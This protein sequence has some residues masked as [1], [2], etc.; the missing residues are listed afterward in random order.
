MDWN[1]DGKI[2]GK[3]HAIYHEV[4]NKESGT[5]SGGSFGGSKGSGQT[6]FEIS[7]LGKLVLGIFGFLLV[8]FIASGSSFA[9][10]WS[11]IQI[12]IIVFLVAQLLDN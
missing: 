5:Q 9:A 4:I 6:T 12:G 3:D 2:D 11:L 8:Y 1:H 7:G 10:I